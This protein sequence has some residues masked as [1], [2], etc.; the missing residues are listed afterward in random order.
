MIK[1]RP[2]FG[3]F[4]ISGKTNLKI[5]FFDTSL[6]CH[7]PDP[8][9]QLSPGRVIAI[10]VAKQSHNGSLDRKV[11]AWIGIVNADAE[12]HRASPIVYSNRQRTQEYRRES[13]TPVS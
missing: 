3:S 11:S 1:T 10:R 8:S 5:D 12:C 2:N 6:T 13:H 7:S 9:D 4:V